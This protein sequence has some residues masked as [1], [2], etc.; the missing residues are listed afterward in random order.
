MIEEEASCW[1]PDVDQIH[2]ASEQLPSKEERRSVCRWHLHVAR[3]TRTAFWNLRNRGIDDQTQKAWHRSR[4]VRD[5]R[6]PQRARLFQRLLRHWSFWECCRRAGWLAGECEITTGGR[7]VL[8]SVI[9]EMVERK[10]KAKTFRK[11]GL[12]KQ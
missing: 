9:D 6:A 7:C 4:S 10:G 2:R 1:G 5:S 11:L 3:S 8:S 12:R